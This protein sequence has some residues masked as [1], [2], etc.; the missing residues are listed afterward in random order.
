LLCVEE[1]KSY[2]FETLVYQSSPL[3]VIEIFV[4]GLGCYH[5]AVKAKQN[6]VQCLR[7]LQEHFCDVDCQEDRNGRTALHM[8]V[9]LQKI[10]L[11][12]CLVSKVNL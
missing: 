3:H 2:F 12:R 8:S 9:E 4:L 5:L 7:L 10:D 11:V 1:A 6:N